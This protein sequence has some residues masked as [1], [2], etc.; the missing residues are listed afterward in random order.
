MKPPIP[1]LAL[2]LLLPGLAASL[3]GCAPSL[4][5]PETLD[6]LAAQAQAPVPAALGEPVSETQPS[7]IGLDRSSWPR[8]AVGP[9]PRTPDYLIGGH[10]DQSPDSYRYRHPELV[11]DDYYPTYFHDAWAQGAPEPV[12]VQSVRRWLPDQKAPV[13]QPVTTQEQ[14]LYALWG[15]RAQNWSADNAADLFV[16]TGRFYYDFALLPWRLVSEPP[17]QRQPGTELQ[18]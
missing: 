8:L 9:S 10:A 3:Y 17:C 1:R 4:R 6:S 13:D 18:H 2:A 5:P 15:A 14:M 12:M 11:Q 16:Q 7:L